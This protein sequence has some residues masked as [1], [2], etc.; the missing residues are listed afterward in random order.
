MK[1]NIMI[2]VASVLLVLV[3]I[4]ACAIS[5]T[6]AKY[7][8]SIT[9]E[10]DARVAKWGF[11]GTDA[12][13]VLDNLFQ[14]VYNNNKVKSDADVIAPGTT[15]SASFKFAYDNSNDIAAPEVAYTFTVDVDACTCAESIKENANIQW[16]LDE[17][18]WGDWDALMT[19]LKKLSGDETDGVKDYA[20][21]TLPDAFNNN[22]TH[23]ISWQWI[24]ET[25]ADANKEDTDMGNAATLAETTIKITVSAV[26]ITESNP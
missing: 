23:T 8:T 24:F 3:I 2:R 15:G 22:Q 1:K 10:D 17:G 20:A 13:I 9:G 19:S 16:K 5:G 18:T 6:F 14:N 4:S 7:T 25:D 26:Q 21:N 11:D 12:D